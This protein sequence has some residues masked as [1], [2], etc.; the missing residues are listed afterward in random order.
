MSPPQT[1]RMPQMAPVPH[2][3]R[4]SSGEIWR[5]TWPQTLTMLTQFLVGFV[6]VQ[7]AGHIHSDVQA[8]LGFITQC[9]FFLLVVGMAA[10]GGAVAAMTQAMGAGLHK[11]TERYSGLIFRLGGLLCM[12]VFIPA[13]CFSGGLLQILQVP[14]AIFDLT[15]E[16]WNLYLF[17][18]PANFLTIVTVA[19]FRAYKNVTIPLF[20]GILVCIINT[21]FDYGLGLGMFGLPNLGAPGLIWASIFSVTAGGVFNLLVLVKKGLI[22]RASFAPWRWERKALPYIV[23]VA[24][25]AGGMSVLWQVGYLVLYSITATLPEG[26][27]T[28]V[29]GLTAGM[30]I[31]AALFMP[32]LAFNLTG[33]VLV[34]NCLGSGDKAEARRVALRVIGAGALSMSVLGIIIYPFVGDIVSLIAQDP[35]VRAVA[36]SYMD[37]NIPAIPFTVT[38]MVMG[39]IMTGA[40]STIYTLVIYSAATWL[41]RLPLAWFMGHQI[42]K[43]AA[44]VFAAMFISQAV[45]A[46]SA[47]Y[48]LLR[49]DWYRFASTAKRIKRKTP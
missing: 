41:V 1:A 39:G 37:Y 12:V 32:A 13:Y 42:W 17:M 33:S 30:R 10:S 44:G 48:V 35:A 45:Q 26:Q 27:V 8:A 20:S 5:L 29:A 25:P 14:D 34:G 31:E 6:D 4:V 23:K 46:A 7:V 24:L 15:R 2:P 47:M 36:V 43:S 16:L 9:L 40:G 19:V 11:R 28:A 21:F 18:L 49:L 22:S 38:S 3:P